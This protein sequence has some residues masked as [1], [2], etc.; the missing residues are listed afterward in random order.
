MVLYGSLP[1]KGG[2]AAM[3][4]GVLA[5]DENGVLHVMEVARKLRKE[6]RGEAAMMVQI[7]AL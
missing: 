1:Q 5:G 4:V 3:T 2:R 6:T 7:L